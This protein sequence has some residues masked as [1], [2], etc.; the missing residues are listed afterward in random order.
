MHGLFTSCHPS[1]QQRR[2]TQKALRERGVQFEA[3]RRWRQEG[4]DCLLAGPDGDAAR[5]L[6]KFLATMRLDAAAELAKRCG[7][8][9]DA[10]ADTRF[11]VL[12]LIDG[13]MIK[14]R[15]KHGLARFALGA[16]QFQII[17]ECFSNELP[18]VRSQ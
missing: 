12:S 8:W 16:A 3:W 13:A 18:H 11:V 4:V 17:R 7:P 15:E 1:G 14:L 2:C 9:V 6:I 10:D 5:D